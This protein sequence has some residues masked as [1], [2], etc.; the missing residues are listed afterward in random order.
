MIENMNNSATTQLPQD[1]G[2]ALNGVL[3]NDCGKTFSIPFDN[4]DGA[5]R[6]EACAVDFYMKQPLAV[7]FYMEQ[8]C[9]FSGM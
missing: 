9:A 5:I 6:C 3:C 4:G 8:P 2:H 7:D 1:V